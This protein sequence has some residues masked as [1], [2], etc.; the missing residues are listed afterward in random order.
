MSNKTFAKL[1]SIILSIAIC[2]TAVLG[3]LITVSEGQKGAAVEIFRSLQDRKN[4][5]NRK[6]HAERGC[7]PKKI[8]YADV[9]E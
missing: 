3:C 6:S 8:Q 1:L 7:S 9:A 2:A 4:F 5:A